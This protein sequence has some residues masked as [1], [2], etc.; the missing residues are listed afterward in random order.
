MDR[1]VVTV[2]KGLKPKRV[3]QRTCV[4]CRESNAKREL[5]RV[6][7]TPTGDVMVDATGR[8]NGRGAYV[9]KDPHCVDLA[10]Q[11]RALDHALKMSIEPATRL[12]LA[13]ALIQ[14][15]GTPQPA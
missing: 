9:H 13:Q 7:R 5:V 4:G 12:A 14:L 3:P 10:V 8:A 11:K 2:P 6:V 15:A 1:G